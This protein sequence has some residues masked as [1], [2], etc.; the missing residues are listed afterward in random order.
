MIELSSRLDGTL[1][2]LYELEK[3]LSRLGITLEEIGIMIMVHST[4][5]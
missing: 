4:I 2:K 5:R 1:F 3:R